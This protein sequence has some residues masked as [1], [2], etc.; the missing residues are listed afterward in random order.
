MPSLAWKRLASTEAGGDREPSWR[1][2]PRASPSAAVRP[3]LNGGVMRIEQ[4]FP[5]TSARSCGQPAPFI[6]AVYGAVLLMAAM[7]YLLL[8]HLILETGDRTMALRRMLGRDL[9]GKLSAV[10]GRRLRAAGVSFEDKQDLLG[11]RSGRITTHYSAAELAKLIEAA[12]R[13]CE[14]DERQPDLVV[15]RGGFHRRPAKRP[16]KDL[17]TTHKS[18]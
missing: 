15:L 6:L 5:M 17:E 3:P 2:A 7:A 1:S 14:R 16:Q 11:H 12:N 18:G 8:Q 4:L 9:K 10:L 13:V